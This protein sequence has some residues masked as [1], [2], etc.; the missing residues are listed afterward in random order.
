[1]EGIA[2]KEGKEN[3][4]KLEPKILEV[5]D[6]PV[7]TGLTGGAEYKDFFKWAE[8]LNKY[9]PD[10]MN[11]VP[12]EVHKGYN[13]LR[14]QTKAY[15]ECTKSLRIF[16]HEQREFLEC[17]RWL[18][19]MKD[20]FKPED[21]FFVLNNAVAGKEAGQ[22]LRDF[23]LD[24]EKIRCP[25]ASTLHVLIPYVNRLVRLFPQLKDKAKDQL[26]LLQIRERV[27]HYGTKRNEKKI[28]KSPLDFKLADLRLGEFLD[29]GQQI[30]QLRMT[31]GDAWTGITKVYRVLQKTTC[32][33]N[34]CS[35][36]HYTILDLERLHMVNRLVN[37][38]ALLAEMDKPIVLM[39]ACGTNQTVN[40]ELRD[41]YKELFNI[42]NR[43]RM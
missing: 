9:H 3:N 23:E 37:L 6:W 38:N 24:A 17:Y 15:D 12:S 14:Y 8:H 21:L 18:R 42:L 29:S 28:D 26:S 36:V 13:L 5:F 27:Y 30:W 1:M 11:T 35:E 32:S 40:D 31:E 19:D 2:P 22:I 20:F 25:E 43:R 34:Y 39:I 41:V 33:S 10:V 16:N 4:D 7:S